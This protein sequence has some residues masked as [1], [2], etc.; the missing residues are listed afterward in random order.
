MNRL[1]SIFDFILILIKILLLTYSLQAF[2]FESALSMA[3]TQWG[4]KTCQKLDEKYYECWQ[5]LKNNFKLT[6]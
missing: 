2:M 6:N 3:V 5:A 4:E 1:L